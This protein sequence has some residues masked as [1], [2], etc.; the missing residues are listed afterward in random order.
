VS[1]KYLLVIANNSSRTGG[2]FMVSPKASLIDGYARSCIV[3]KAAGFK[4]AS[5]FTCD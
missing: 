5:V 2:G 1:Q 4:T 3:R